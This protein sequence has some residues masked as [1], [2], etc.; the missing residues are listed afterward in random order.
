VKAF[1]WLSGASTVLAAALLSS[2]AE[3]PKISAS[4]PEPVCG[5]TAGPH[6]YLESSSV[7]QGLRVELLADSPRAGDPCI[8]RFSVTQQPKNLPVDKLQIE[9]E[10]FMHVLAVRDDLSE[11]F[12]IHPIRTAPGRWEA[13]HT[14]AQGGKYKLWAEVKYLG[15]SYSFGQPW[16]TV[17]GASSRTAV[18]AEKLDCVEIGGCRVSLDHAGQ[19]TAG[20]TNQ[21]QLTVRDGS[22]NPVE[23]ENYLGTPMHLFIVNHDASACLHAHPESASNAR[24]TVRFRQSFPGPGTYNLFAQFRAKKNELPTDGALL[25]Q[26]AVTVRPKPN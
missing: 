4:L 17:G 19:M 14:F 1:S 10:K 21:F 9:H 5:F 25:A 2:V 13:T 26:F 15:T 11:F 23:L 24:G 22:G 16:L 6:F 7:R 3:D 20:E 18:P 12:H 8:L